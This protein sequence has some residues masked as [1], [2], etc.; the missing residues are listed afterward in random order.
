MPSN[1]LAALSRAQAQY[2][3]GR[4][5][6]CGKGWG[7]EPN[8]PRAVAW[9]RRAADSD[10]IDAMATLAPL[11]RNGSRA[12]EGFVPADLK[13]SIRLLSSA[14]SQ[15]HMG[16]QVAMG[17]HLFEGYGLPKNVSRALELWALAAA[18]GCPTAKLRYQ[19]SPIC[20]VKVPCVSPRIA[21][22]ACCGGGLPHWQARECMCQ[23]SP[24]H[25]INV[26]CMTC[27]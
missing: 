3:V 16:A 20:P 25:P 9:L 1:T 22:G 7:S 6:L 11:L 23:K 26:P 21:L 18:A 12:G 24:M 13:R 14:A 15:G 10:H 4:A 17:D 5:Y 19:K 8:L 27:N 2:E